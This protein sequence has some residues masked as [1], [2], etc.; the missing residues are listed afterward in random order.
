MTCVFQHIY[1]FSGKKKEMK[2]F[3]DFQCGRN[4]HG[5]WRAAEESCG[6]EWLNWIHCKWNSVL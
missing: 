1:T 3:V 4:E 5:V 6:I 2:K